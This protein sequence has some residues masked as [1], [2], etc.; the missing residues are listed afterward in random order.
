MNSTFTPPCCAARRISSKRRPVNE[1]KLFLDELANKLIEIINEEIEKSIPEIKIKERNSNLPEFIRQKIKNKR[2]LRRLYI[3]TKDQKIKP[4][5]N[6][7]K[8]EIKKDIINY[9]EKQWEN[10]LRKI[11]VSSD[12]KDW[13]NIK[14]ILGMEKDKI[15]YPD[16]TLGNKKAMTNEEKVKLFKQFLET[17]FITEPEH[18]ILDQEKKLIEMEILK[19]EDL[20]TI[21]VNENHKDI[22]IDEL[23]SIVKKLDIKKA[24]GEDKITNKHMIALK[25]L[26]LNCLIVLFTMGTIP[27]CSKNH[28]LLCFINLENPNRK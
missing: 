7:I 10:K 19:D 27:R 1:I 22:K 20:D 12:P 24:C 15:K 4:T 9:R 2:S 16:L 14:N 13:R 23:T 6:S 26:S 28:K 8:K 21:K 3:Q 17:I 11:K 25:N 18:K 5:L